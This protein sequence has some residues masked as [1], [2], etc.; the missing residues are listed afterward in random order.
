[1]RGENRLSGNFLCFIANSL[2]SFF[3]LKLMLFLFL[4]VK[5]T[6]LLQHLVLFMEELHFDVSAHWQRLGKFK[7]HVLVLASR[8]SRV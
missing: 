7:N 8:M 2:K 6:N 5:K 4:A 1:M 3:W